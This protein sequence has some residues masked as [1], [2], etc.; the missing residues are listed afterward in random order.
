MPD[1]TIASFLLTGFE[2]SPD[3]LLVVDRQLRVLAA[4]AAAAE[5][6]GR[7]PDAAR[8]RELVELLPTALGEPLLAA[9]HRSAGSQQPVAL[10]PTRVGDERWVAP[11]VMPNDAGFMLVL[12]DVSEHKHIEAALR[13]SEEE[14]RFLTEAIPQQIWTARPDGGLDFANRR[15]LDYFGKPAEQILGDRWAELVHPDDLPAVSARWQTSLR[16]GEPYEVEFRLRDAGGDY[17]WH[18]GRARAMRGPDGQIV[19]WFGTNIDIDDQKRAEH[20]QRFILEASAELAR[21]R[22]YEDTLAA[23]ARLAVQHVADWCSVV[24]RDGDGLRYVA[25]AHVDPA[26]VTFAR[27][28]QRRYP[29]DPGAA[30]GVPQVIRTGRAELVPDVEAALPAAVVRDREQLQILR[31]LRIRSSMVV[32]LR[33][34]DRTIGAINFVSAE[35]GCRYGPADLKVAED[36]AHRCSLAFEHAALLAQAQVAEHE[37]RRLN[38]ELERRVAERTGELQRA[39]DRLAEANARLKELDLMKDE[40]L[41]ALS[42]QLASPIHTVIG[43][44]ET[45]LEGAGG[46]LREE[47][48]SYVRRIGAWSRLLLSLVNDLLDM[49]RMSGGKFALEL[50]RVDVSALARDVLG[51]LEPVTAMQG[52]RVVADITRDPL[53]ALADE[54]RLEQVLFAVLHS[55]I[56]LTASAGLLRVST[57][58]D[59][60]ALRFEV[61]HTGESL[62]RDEVERIL[63]RY[64]SR[65][66]A[67]LG[68]SI[69]RRIVEDHGGEMGVEPSAAGGNTFWFTL[70]LLPDEP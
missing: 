56:Q 16:T 7:S 47:Q 30:S 58:V 57:E 17:R 63:H 70:P 27:E 69:A 18:I 10:A 59:G 8:D 44:T 41:G 67:W 20:A 54:R 48:Q 64:S 9:L 36:L 60:R 22:D 40:F 11:R 33:D 6:I 52:H 37:L 13:H 42:Y 31:A 43:Y 50:A 2:R 38:E 29:L 53:E 26:K 35:S 23:V 45:L 61:Y 5:L 21:A 34:H 1:S 39:R 49:T 24:L 19:R 3:P 14:Y 66:G 4:N 46:H 62:G 68:L 51:A 32:P 15:V 25:V 12:R 65:Q 28:V 55:A